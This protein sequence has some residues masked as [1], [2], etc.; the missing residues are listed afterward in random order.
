MN[1]EK[2]CSKDVIVNLYLRYR[3]VTLWE[4]L[5]DSLTITTDNDYEKCDVAEDTIL[6]DFVPC[7]LSG[8][9]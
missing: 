1:F 7:R 5:G 2:L 6:Y 3:L 4:N 8:S 9:W